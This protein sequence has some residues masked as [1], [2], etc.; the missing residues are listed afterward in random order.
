MDTGA[1]SIWQSHLF[2]SLDSF[3]HRMQSISLTLNKFLRQ[4]KVNKKDGC[5]S[6]LSI[7]S[8]IF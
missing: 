3:D 2:K 4:V 5:N 1:Y 8:S 7:L 6:H